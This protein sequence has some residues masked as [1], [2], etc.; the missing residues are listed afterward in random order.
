MLRFL[1]LFFIGTVAGATS[2][3]LPRLMTSLAAGTAT[4]AG[5]SADFLSNDFMVMAGGFSLL[6]GLITAILCQSGDAE[7]DSRQVFFYSLGIPALVSGTLSTV[8]GANS[9]K[10]Q[11]LEN[12]NVL[13]RTLGAKNIDVVSWGDAPGANFVGGR[14]RLVAAA[15]AQTP[16]ADPAAAPPTASGAVAWD[17]LVKQLAARGQSAKTAAGWTFQ[18]SISLQP[19]A[20]LLAVGRYAAADEAERGLTKARLRFP[21]AQL[22]VRDGGYFLVRDTAPL[23]LG[24]AT[25]EAVNIDARRIDANQAP[26]LIRLPQ[27][28]QVR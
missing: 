6:L 18:P 27:A 8:D 17:E 25:V 19:D 21:N 7:I 4:G 11:A 28:I 9:L 20:Y 22:V 5:Q 24:Q 1:Y 26:A 12:K 10:L 15:H 14:W 23:N 3:F 13:E 16:P 2:A